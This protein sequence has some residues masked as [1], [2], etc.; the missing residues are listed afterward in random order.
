L[1]ARQAGQASVTD[2]T[3]VNE[4]SLSELTASSQ[5][6]NIASQIQILDKDVALLES[7]YLND[8]EPDV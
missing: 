5:C 3:P 7:I 4:A 6:S 1:A 2:N 8:Q